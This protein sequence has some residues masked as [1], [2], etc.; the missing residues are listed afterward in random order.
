MKIK[1]QKP[2][3]KQPETLVIPRGPGLDIALKIGPVHSFTEFEAICGKAPQ[4]PRAWLPG[5]IQG[6]PEPNKPEF[7][8]RLKEYNLIQSNWM[9]IKSLSY[10]E[11]L[12]WEKVVLEDKNTWKFWREELEEAFLPI[13]VK[14]IEVKILEVN[15]LTDG[16]YDEANKRFLSGQVEAQQAAE[17][18]QTQE[19]QNTGSGEPVNT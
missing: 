3:L 10:T 7:Q 11:D 16:A 5:G 2:T 15:S 12:T 14:M 18:S 17:S 13:E 19:P 1:N 9:M 6:P 4:P 8:E